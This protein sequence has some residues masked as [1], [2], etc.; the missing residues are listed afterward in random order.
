MSKAQLLRQYIRGTLRLAARWKQLRQVDHV[1]AF[2]HFAFAIKLL[3]RL[4]LIRYRKLF[5]FAFFVHDPK[6]F[7]LCRQLVRLDGNN[8][9]YLVFSRSELELYRGQLG[10]EEQRLV[11]LPYGDWGQF[12]WQ[13]RAD[14]TKPT[15]DYYLAGGSSNRDYA[16]LV[17]AFRSIR[18]R[19]VIVCAQSNW[20]ELRDLDISENVAVLQ[21][22]PSDVFESLV[23]G[24]K[25]GI[26]PLKLDTGASGQ[27]VALAHTRNS[28]CVIASDAGALREYIDHGVSGF[29]LRS[30][31]ELPE[32]IRKI[33]QEALAEPMGRAARQKYDQQFSRQVV[34]DAFDELLEAA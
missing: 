25:A 7:P 34:A 28:Q 32:T 16:G 12:N 33:E 31:A 17:E 29:L 1:V 27:S 21:D 11:Y 24:S 14:W 23:R 22:V 20:E 4:G 13:A 9:L 26:I 10:I 3:A 18:A 6:L 30:L 15:R 2:G 8:D 19:L 5:C